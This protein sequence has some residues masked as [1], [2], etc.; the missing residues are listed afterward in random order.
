MKREMSTVEP[1]LVVQNVEP[2]KHLCCKNDLLKI[3]LRYCGTLPH[4]NLYLL[5]K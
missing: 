1:V 5:H 2:L 3:W 4:C